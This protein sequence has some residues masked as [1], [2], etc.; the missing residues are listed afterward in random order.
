[1][2][3]STSYEPPARLSEVPG[4]SPIIH[5]FADPKD[6]AAMRADV[7]AAK[8]RADVVVVSWHWGMSKAT[9]GPNAGKVIE[10]QIAMAHEA[11]DV[12]ADF[13]MGHHPHVLEGIEVY[14]GKA[15]FYSLGNFAF[16]LHMDSQDTMMARCEIRNGAIERV[17][18]MP[19]RINEQSQP[20]PIDPEAGQDIVEIVAGLS[21]EFDTRFEVGESDVTVEMTATS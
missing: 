12:G 7:A 21:A 9:G 16:D 8:R 20:V 3:V 13:V 14:N 6:A 1:V 11:I 2:R 18:F 5:T 4:A 19:T 10:Y 15:I 17:S